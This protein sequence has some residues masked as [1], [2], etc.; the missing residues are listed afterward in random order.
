M[1]DK[2]FFNLV[3]T[4]IKVS[5]STPAPEIYCAFTFEYRGDIRSDQN[6]RGVYLAAGGW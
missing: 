1:G 6:H 4:N 3:K 2:S 5:A